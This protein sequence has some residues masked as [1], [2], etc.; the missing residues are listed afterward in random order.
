MK[1]ISFSAVALL[2]GISLF[3]QDQPNLRTEMTRAVRF[4]IKAGV[5]IAKMKTGDNPDVSTNTKTSMG[6]GLLVN[7]PVGAGGF[8]VQPEILYNGMGGKFT[9]TLT[10]GGTESSEADLH[11][12]SLPIMFQ[13]KATNGFFLELGPQASYLLKATQEVN[14]TEEDVKD[15]LDKFD[16]A[17]AGGVG[18]MSRIGL[19][20]GARYIYGLSDVRED[21][22]TNL[23]GELKNRVFHVGLFYHFGAAK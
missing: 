3:A 19:G 18:F 11:Y 2:V 14:S 9:E 13:W 15:Q 16:I 22:G 1:K 8:A 12:L 23:T 21:N 17:A 10:L 4:G 5:N 20:I 7:L 6:G